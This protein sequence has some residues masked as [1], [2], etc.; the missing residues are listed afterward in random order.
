MTQEE[1]DAF[2][3]GSFAR[4]VGSAS[5]GTRPTPVRLIQAAAKRLTS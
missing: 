3:T 2:Y 4:L 5:A 1:F